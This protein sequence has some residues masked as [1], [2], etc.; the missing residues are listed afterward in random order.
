MSAKRGAGRRLQVVPGADAP[1][2][3]PTRVGQIWS[4]APDPEI[5]LPPG[6]AYR[7]VGVGVA[8][9]DA[10]G[11][12]GGEE[13]RRVCS[14]A[15]VAGWATDLATGAVTV[16][17][18]VAVAGEWRTCT[19]PPSALL[20]PRRVGALADTGIE[21]PKA[22]SAAAYLNSGYHAVRERTRPAFGTQ[23][24]GIQRVAGVPVA[25]L[26]G[27]G[28]PAAP[29][30][31]T[32]PEIGF[33]DTSGVEFVRAPRPDV[34]G[35]R[36]TARDVWDHL[37]KLGD[38]RVLA[39]ILAW[40]VAALWAPEVRAAMGGRFPLLNVWASRGSG[41]TTVLE[42]VGMAVGGGVQVLT[43]RA[44][45]FALLRDL[46][47]STTIPVICDE[48]RR[49][50]LSDHQQGSLHDLL[51]R[52]YDGSSDQRGQQDQ[53]V[54][55]YR[56]QSPAVLAGES[57]I[58][59]PALADRA[60]L[61]ALQRADLIEWPGGRRA[62]AWL[63]GHPDECRR[64]AGWLLQRRLDDS[65]TTP[66]ALAAT[67][68]A[69]RAELASHVDRLGVALPERAVDGLAVAAWAWNWLADIGLPVELVDWAEQV[70]RAADLRRES[71]PVDWLIQ[72][73]ESAAG[74]A[75]HP[76]PMEADKPSGQLRVG[77]AAAR[78]GF[79]LWCRDHGNPRL[80]PE[81]ELAQCRAY[82]TKTNVRIFGRQ[83][84]SW[85]FD[86]TGL[87]DEFGIDREFW[88]RT[89]RE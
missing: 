60:I 42:L 70:R 10:A 36:D 86:L 50:E 66:Q 69:H 38:P 2:T 16:R 40:H 4:T 46:S 28:E 58:S 24:A 6:Y 22:A 68:R 61:V 83:T 9:E 63:Q 8:D 5:P 15:Y 67:L 11:E 23:V 82:V 55:T 78:A 81:P 7:A 75:R 39:P 85:V 47:A 30:G 56:L 27:L 33:T 74:D 72:F 71:G 79:D 89:A 80:D 41:K 3:G 37:W 88:P 77:V 32:P 65:A 43:A 12:D 18:A 31:T 48:Y 1:A 21:M 49:G 35:T 26:P 57:R 76:V 13:W 14:P 53:T 29:T 17:V 87:A 19:V 34:R 84:K 54:R 62:L 25:V 73:L 20:D 64:A 52:A 59:D 51:R 44:T 45:R